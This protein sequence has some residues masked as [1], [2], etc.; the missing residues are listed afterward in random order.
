MTFGYAF[1]REDIVLSAHGALSYGYFY[2]AN[3]D[4]RPTGR[5]TPLR[6]V[7]LAGNHIGFI[8]EPK[9]VIF[10]QNLS[11]GFQIDVT[12]HDLR[13]AFILDLTHICCVVPRRQKGRRADGGFVRIDL[14]WHCVHSVTEDRSNVGEGLEIVVRGFPAKGLLCSSQKLATS[15]G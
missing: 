7:A 3:I 9:P 11:G 2:N 1:T 12:G 6:I 8:I 10:L 4:V 5:C 14:P 13:D 15:R